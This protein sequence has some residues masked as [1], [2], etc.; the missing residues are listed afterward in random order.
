MDPWNAAIDHLLGVD[1]RETF[2]SSVTVFHDA[3]RASVVIR[4]MSRCLDEHV[5]PYYTGE[6]PRV[7]LMV[8]LI[9]VL[10]TT[11][12]VNAH[13]FRPYNMDVI[14]NAVE[15]LRYR[16]AAGIWPNGRHLLRRVASCVV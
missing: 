11:L 9:T 16:V 2:L 10:Y 1:N 12:E 5:S 7:S 14:R 4:A 6:R 13:L 3:R 15:L 8:E